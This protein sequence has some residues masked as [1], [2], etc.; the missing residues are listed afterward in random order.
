MTGGKRI[1]IYTDL[2]G[3][4]LDHKTYSFAESKSAL[5]AAQ[6]RGIP[7]VFCSSKTRAEIEPLR[8]ELQVKDPFIVENGGAAI[9]PAGYSPFFTEVRPGRGDPMI[10]LGTPYRTLVEAV[11]D[12]RE[13][14]PNKI[15]SFSNM[16][17]EE[18]AHDCDLSLDQARLAKKREFDEPFRL[19]DADDRTRERILNEIRRLGL[20]CSEGGR[21]YHLHG[22]NDKGMAV[23]ILTRFAWRHDLETF[24]V[25]L[26]D[27]LNDL[28]MLETAD[29]PVL[30]KRPDG[31]HHPGVIE[32]LP[33][34]HLTRGV[35]PI[36][37][38]ETVMSLLDG[39]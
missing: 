29:Y 13:A 19:V 1:I 10:V 11:N 39:V 12:L 8:Q 3:S 21:Y 6:A 15:I 27:S 28:T 5:A 14:F 32:L 30:I 17:V 36:G 38:S 33:K 25:G 18:I 9:I 34:I 35:G 23:R 2:D 26:G 37:W 31:T 4:L 7:I 24:S 16:T 20:S 22:G